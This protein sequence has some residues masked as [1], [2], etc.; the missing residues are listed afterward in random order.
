[1]PRIVVGLGNPGPEYEGT[2]HN[3]GFAVVDALARRLRAADW[4]RG[5]ASLWV[6]ASWRDEPVVLLKPQTYM[7]RSGEAVR[8]VV[9]AW[10]VAPGDLLVVYDD[11]DL[12]LGHL[13]LRP[14]GS[15][16]GHRG[17]A[18]IIA[19]LG[20]DDFPRL[21]VGIGRPPRGVDAADYVLAP[22]APMERPLVEA[23]VR[24]AV[25]AILAVLAAGLERAM[26]RYNGPTPWPSAGA[27]PAV[28]G[29]GET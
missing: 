1:M 6:E 10:R 16:G 21:R 29:G 7:N 24:R 28:G 17:V 27:D 12:P 8:Q 19:A 3:V 25:E 22:F 4:R 15:A 11:M 20:R 26:S 5:F 2:R 13:R 18:S 23:A 9:G 14:R